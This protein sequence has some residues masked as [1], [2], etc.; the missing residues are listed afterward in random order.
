MLTML[1]MLLMLRRGKERSSVLAVERER[2]GSTA[3]GLLF[4]LG[5]DKPGAS[6]RRFGW[7]GTRGG[8]CRS[9][10]SVN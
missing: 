7:M 5:P 9:V 6:W 8:V 2:V 1:L 4:W 3:L 10:L